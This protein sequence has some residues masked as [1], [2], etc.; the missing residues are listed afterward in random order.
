MKVL[1]PYI[2]YTLATDH[3]IIVL[4]SFRGNIYRISAAASKKFYDAINSPNMLDDNNA[5]VKNKI[6]VDK[7]CYGDP[8]TLFDEFASKKDYLHLVILPTEDCNFR[9]TYCYEEHHTLT[10]SEWVESSIVRFVEKHLAEYNALRI[11]WFGGEP[12]FAKDI[13][14]RLSEKFNEICKKLHKPYYASMTTNGYFLDVDTFKALF[15]SKV[16]RYQITLDGLKPYHDKQRF[17]EDGSGSFDT[18]LHNLRSIRDEIHSNFFNITIRCNITSENREQF[19]EYIDFLQKEFGDDIRFS[20]LWKIAWNPGSNACESYLGQ[21]ALKTVLMES[22]SKK[23]NL[24][25]NRRQMTK[26]GNICYASN[27][28]SFIVGANGDLFKC[29]VAFDKD[30]NKIGVLLDNGDMDIDQAKFRYWTEKKT[31]YNSICSSCY[32]YPS[33]LGIYCNLN[34]ADENGHFVCSGFKRYVDDY[35]NCFNEC[36]INIIDLEI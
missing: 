15:R 6:I 10:M 22:A 11:E 1:S 12:L 2:H 26:F 28:N 25:T 23:M 16:L 4:D 21:N 17:L 27:K 18:I 33:C 9:C 31:S 14:F 3:N 36:G 30:I 8:D 24:D 7:D 13:V 19:G 32:L 29:T 34:N 5:L 35:L 20:F